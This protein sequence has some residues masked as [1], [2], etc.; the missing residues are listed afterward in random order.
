MSPRTSAVESPPALPEQ[1]DAEDVAG[2]QPPGAADVQL[3]MPRPE[4]ALIVGEHADA[5]FSSLTKADISSSRRAS[6]VSVPARVVSARAR[7]TRAGEWPSLA[8]EPAETAP[9]PEPIDNRW[10]DL[11]PDVPARH[12]DWTHVLSGL[13]RARS[14]EREQ[15]GDY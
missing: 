7:R 8:Y 14:L 11:P 15:R 4:P 10:P 12:D 2:T 13:R 5:P 1:V 9:A 6:I 3:R